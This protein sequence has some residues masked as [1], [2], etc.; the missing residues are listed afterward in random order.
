ME[1]QRFDQ[2]RSHAPQSEQ[3]L[4]LVVSPPMLADKDVLSKMNLTSTEVSMF[5]RR[6]FTEGVIRL[7]Q[8]TSSSISIILQMII[9]LIE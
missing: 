4:M 6:V 9:S 1:N 3:I 8:I 5:K 2:V 7:G